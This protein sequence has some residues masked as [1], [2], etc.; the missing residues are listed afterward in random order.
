MAIGSPGSFRS[1]GWTRSVPSLRASLPQLISGIAGLAWALI[2]LGTWRLTTSTADLIG[3]SPGDFESHVASAYA[4]MR[5]P[6]DWS[7]PFAVSNLDV[8]TG[9][10]IFTNDI[11]PAAVLPMR[12]LHQLLGVTLDPQIV[13]ALLSVVFFSLGCVSIARLAATLGATPLAALCSGLLPLL[14]M[15]LIQYVPKG[16]VA[17]SGWFVIVLT[18]DT[19]IRIARGSRRWSIFVRLFL[20]LNLALWINPY[21]ALSVLILTGFALLRALLRGEIR[22][23]STMIVLILGAG[24]ILAASRPGGGLEL[25]T[26]GTGALGL[27]SR[28][29]EVGF[30]SPDRD[31]YRG[32]VGNWG[33]AFTLLALVALPRILRLGAVGAGALLLGLYATGSPVAGAFVPE[34]VYQTLPLGALGSIDRLVIPLMILSMAIGPG[35]AAEWITAARSRF[36]KLVRTLPA[37]GL[38]S[39]LIVEIIMAI[40]SPNGALA[41]TRRSTPEPLGYRLIAIEKLMRSHPLVTISPDHSCYADYYSFSKGQDPSDPSLAREVTAE[42][43]TVRIVGRAIL[44]V[45]DTGGSLTNGLGA[46]RPFCPYLA[47]DQVLPPNA[48]AILFRSP[49]VDEHPDDPRIVARTL[50]AT[51]ICAESNG[52]Y[53]FDPIEQISERDAPLVIRVCSERHEEII[54]LAEEID[55]QLTRGDDPWGVASEIR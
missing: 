7:R 1:A 15:P 43:N 30:T 29:F 49:I 53:I 18:I 20:L 42:F 44:S 39:L 37:L 34:I 3:R 40:V 13:L 41:T 52:F 27:G 54:A 8:P 21:H 23:G 31:L 12:L 14:A 2:W 35:L 38:A 19:L 16:L 46:R 5:D 10:T 25:L 4:A 51:Y 32:Y 26:G 45:A 50:P 17:L 6:I 47:Y 55:A 33:L 24:G 11:V 36:G 28:L 22:I 9:T 48:L